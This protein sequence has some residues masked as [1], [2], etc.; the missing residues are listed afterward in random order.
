[1]YIDYYFTPNFEI[2]QKFLGDY[3]IE[4]WNSKPATPPYFSF[5][6]GIKMIF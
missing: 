3:A 6:L 4:D 2:T 1:L 5:G